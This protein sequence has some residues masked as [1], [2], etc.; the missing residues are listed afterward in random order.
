MNCWDKARK[1]AGFPLL[2]LDQI[3]ITTAHS[4]VWSFKLFDRNPVWE[5]FQTRKLS[6]CNRHW[7]LKVPV[8]IAWK[9]MI[10]VPWSKINVQIF[11]RPS[12]HSQSNSW[13][14]YESLFIFYHYTNIELCTFIY[15]RYE[16]RCV[17]GLAGLSNLTLSS[18]TKDNCKLLQALIHLL[19]TN[20]WARRDSR[21]KPHLAW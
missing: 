19:N 20:Q 5:L 13:L 2:K 15:K 9:S 17:D 3:T 8:N 10:F 7:K 1:S 11:P 14:C 12:Y 16:M 18:R 6:W 4:L 21:R